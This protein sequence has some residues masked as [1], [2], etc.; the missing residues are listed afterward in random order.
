MRLPA[1]DFNDLNLW[2]SRNS[3][4]HS[5]AARRRTWLKLAKLISNGVPILQAL[6]TMQERRL[7]LKSASDPM[8]VA[9]TDW[10]A[11]MRNGRRFAEAIDGWVPEE[12]R[13][14]IASGEASGTLE[15]SL[16]SACTQII[17]GQEIRGAL[18]AGFAYPA[19][20]I[21][22][23]FGVLVLFGYK[24]IPAFSGVIGDKGWQGMAASMVWVADFVQHWLWLVAVVL[25]SSIAA[26]FVSLPR[27]DGRTRIFLDLYP[28]YSIY[29][30]V[31]GSAWIIAVAS[32]VEAGER[33][34]N[35][36]KMLADQ[37]NPWMRNRIEACLAGMRSGHNLGEALARA[38]HG[39]PD[40][41]VIDDLG[42]Y[43][44]L[45][46]FDQ[47]LSLIGREMLTETVERIKVS[48]RLVFGVGLLLVAGI[49]AWMISGM[50]AMQTQMGQIMQHAYQ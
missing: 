36:L 44:S 30:T 49:I 48:M 25:V 29:R 22:L 46:G 20:L 9:L 18:V 11:H 8:V 16:Q 37:A 27:W 50:I 31:K 39:F 7:K 40:Q 32:L 38:G 26:F 1:L 4:R 17:S 3:I 45:S 5:G 15:A 14:L 34:E 19:I 21:V 12:E 2:W 24:I 10:I 47:A 23:A 42:V 33:M 13:M 41:E 35:A 28:P 6:Q 43:S